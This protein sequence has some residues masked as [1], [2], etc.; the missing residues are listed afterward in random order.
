MEVPFGQHVPGSPGNNDTLVSGVIDLVFLEEEG[1]VI[2]DYKTDTV[3][4]DE[5]LYRLVD[6]YSPQLD[7]YRSFWEE[8]AGEKVLETG[9]YFTSVDRWVPLNFEESKQVFY[10]QTIT[11]GDSSEKR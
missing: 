1:W 5:E 11:G 7:L 9:L 2:V 4:D 6:Y 3:K 8:I 10:K